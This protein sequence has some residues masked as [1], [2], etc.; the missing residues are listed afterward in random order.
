MGTVTKFL[1]LIKDDKTDV[2][3]IDKINDNLDKIDAGIEKIGTPSNLKT[4]SKAN[5]VDSIN[6]LF[7][8]IKNNIKKL[9]EITKPNLVD[10]SSAEWKSLIILF[11]HD[12]S[13]KTKKKL[14]NFL[15]KQD[16]SVDDVFILSAKIKYKIDDTLPEKKAEIS[17]RAKGDVTTE[18][19]V[20][21]STVEKNG[22]GEFTYTNKF[23]LTSNQLT[24]SVFNFDMMVSNVIVG[25]IR[26]KELK[27]EKGETTTDWCYSANDVAVLDQKL[28]KYTRNWNVHDD[29]VMTSLILNLLQAR[30]EE[31]NTVQWISINNYFEKI[32]QQVPNFDKRFMSVIMRNNDLKIYLTGILPNSYSKS[33]QL[34]AFNQFGGILKDMI[35]R[36]S[37]FTLLH[38]KQTSSESELNN[39]CKD[40]NIIVFAT[41]GRLNSYGNDESRMYSNW[42]GVT[43]LID[44]GDL[45]NPNGVFVGRPVPIGFTN[46]TFKLDSSG[47]VAIEVYKFTDDNIDYRG[48]FDNLI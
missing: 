27:I 41:L 14:G 7:I 9:D 31:N 29:P 15:I 28:T 12:G 38:K 43:K 44:R 48:C 1:K 23:K 45:Q 47:Y 34:N 39:C 2:Y 25:E 24:N 30:G 19:H 8:K 37:R 21:S 36:D 4:I 18:E 17:L 3:D 32:R 10:N 33:L 22:T 35:N 13:P 40:K 42:F 11:N 5:L 20:I 6:E 16:Y 46:T 26:V